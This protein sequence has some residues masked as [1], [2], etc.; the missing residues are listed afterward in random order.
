MAKSSPNNMCTCA[1]NNGE[2]VC[3]GKD[4]L[5]ECEVWSKKLRIQYV[6]KGCLHKNSIKKITWKKGHTNFG[7]E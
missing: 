1:L 2:L 5:T 3:K 6:T 4:I 7:N